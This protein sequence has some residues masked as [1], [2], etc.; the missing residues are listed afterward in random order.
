[1]AQASNS[2]YAETDKVRRLQSQAAVGRSFL[3]LAVRRWL[4][5]NIARRGGGRK[6]GD[7]PQDPATLSTAPAKDP[8]RPLHRLGDVL[9]WT[10]FAAVE[11]PDPS[12]I[13]ETRV[14]KP[15]AKGKI[16]AIIEV[17]S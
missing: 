15:R 8:D 6:N 1:M 10:V 16:M 4:Y 12:R 13:S 7:L 11:P 17:G 9:R 3:N 2:L 14:P 5:Q